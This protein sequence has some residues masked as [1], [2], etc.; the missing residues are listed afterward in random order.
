[1]QMGMSAILRKISSITNMMAVIPRF[2][3]TWTCITM[4]ITT[5]EILI[6]QTWLA[7]FSLTLCP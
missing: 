7:A 2:I 4:I 5:M 3:L 6:A 1:M